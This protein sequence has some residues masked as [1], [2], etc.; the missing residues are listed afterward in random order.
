[1]VRNQVVT[2]GCFYPHWKVMEST[3]AIHNSV[4]EKIFNGDLAVRTST[5]EEIKKRMVK[6]H[7]ILLLDYFAEG[8]IHQ[9]VHICDV[10][11]KR[12]LLT[13]NFIF[14]QPEL[15]MGAID[16]VKEGK[17]HPDMIHLGAPD[18]S[19]IVSVTKKETAISEICKACQVAI[20]K[21]LYKHD[22]FTLDF[23]C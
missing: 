16:K 5:L 19:C 4:V 8:D 20:L 9:I 17:I 3:D 2:C 15:Y 21:C 11:L 1:M 22:A 10:C 7:N 18:N 14:V 6:F 12:I 13:Q 23:R